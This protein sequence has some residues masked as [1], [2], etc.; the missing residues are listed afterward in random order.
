MSTISIS[1]NIPYNYI[2]PISR[3]LKTIS[4]M[5]ELSKALKTCTSC[6]KQMSF[7]GI[8][9]FFIYIQIISKWQKG[10]FKT[11]QTC[12]ETNLKKIK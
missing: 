12:E 2:V 6:T 11:H 4:L 3:Y 8:S 10:F 7:V 1:G 5:Q 9:I